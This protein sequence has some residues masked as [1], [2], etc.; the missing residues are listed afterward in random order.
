MAARI[1]GAP[2]S[3]PEKLKGFRSI[4][5]ATDSTPTFPAPSVARTSR[6]WRPSE[7]TRNASEYAIQGPPSNRYSREETPDHSSSVSIRTRTAEEKRPGDSMVP[8]RKT[9]VAGG[10]VSTKSEANT[11]CPFA[12][13]RVNDATP[14]P[15]GMA[16]KEAPPPPFPWLITWILQGPS[17]TVSLTSPPQSV[18]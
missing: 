8:F 10:R 3:G 13:F 6:T 18:A 16:A 17:F 15:S 12:S 5:N 9:R 4:T 14:V 1:V 2:W 7:E 11:R